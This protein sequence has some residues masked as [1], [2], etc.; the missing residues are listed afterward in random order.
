[1]RP[2]HLTRAADALWAAAGDVLVVIE[3]GTPAGFARIRT[4]RA[5]LIGRGAHAV[6]PC[7]HDRPCPIVDAEWCHFAQR[8]PSSRAHRQVKGAA[9]AFEDEKFAYVALARARRPIAGARVLAHPRV[10]KAEV[11]AKLCTE[12]RNHRGRPPAG[13]RRKAT[14]R[15]KGWRWGDWVAWPGVKR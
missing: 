8:L 9:L 1:M 3:P 12:E 5:H 7:P 14:G 6:A 13:A 2:D 10:T 11:R 4:L 15:Q